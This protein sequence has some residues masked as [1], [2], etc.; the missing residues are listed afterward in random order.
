M[1]FAIVNGGLLLGFYVGS[2][3]YSVVDISHV[4]CR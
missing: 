4:I 2:R 1:F 3:H